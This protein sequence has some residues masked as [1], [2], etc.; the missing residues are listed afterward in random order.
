[1]FESVFL[2]SECSD[3]GALHLL[4]EF[5]MMLYVTMPLSVPMRIIIR[6]KVKVV[7]ESMRCHHSVKF[8][9]HDKSWCY[10]VFGCF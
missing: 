7:I 3:S 5:D 2:C 6:V 8:V 10:W 4:G 1:V 9:S